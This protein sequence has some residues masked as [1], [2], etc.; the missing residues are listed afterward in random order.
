MICNIQSSTQFLLWD[1]DEE[2]KE[3]HKKIYQEL[4]ESH[5]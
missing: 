4:L 3:C 1:Q 5:E 2:Q